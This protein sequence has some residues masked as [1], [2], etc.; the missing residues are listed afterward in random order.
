MRNRRNSSFAGE[1]GII[2]MVVFTG[3]GACSPDNDNSGTK[4][5]AVA[6]DVTLSD[7]QRKN[8]RLYTVPE[9][10]YR[11]SVDAVGAVDFDSDQATSVLAPFSGPVA[12][13]FVTPGERVKKGQ[14]LATVASPDFA[15]AV[16]AYRKAV[17]AAQSARRLAD[18]DKDLL[19]HKGVSEREADQAESDAVGAEA[20]RA[21]ALQALVSLD[22]DPRTIA[23]I[24]RG[25]QS[26]H[27]EGVIRAPISGTVVEKLITPGQLLQ[28]GTTACFTVADLSRVW[29][30]AQVFGA[31]L[32]SI[33]VGDPATVSTG[34]ASLFGRVDN[35]AAEVDPNTRS[36]AVRVA[37][38]NPA[39][40]LKKQ[41]YVRARIESRAATRALMIPVS[42]VLRDDENLPFVY[43]MEQD[44]RFA[45]RHVTL[46]D[47]T[48]A[49][50]AIPSGLR[51]GERIVADGALF[52]QFMQEQ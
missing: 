25:Q 3:L 50:Y 34:F 7:A 23:D 26:S 48:G 47:R 20:D 10:A 22:I 32:G 2:L 49:L 46:G 33:H 21:A 36:V 6:S 1:I 12:R 5:S 40:T 24:R 51:A 45:R 42:G 38:D 35:I 8:I 13:I 15:A 52:L 31:D 28:A 37:V 41:M 17:A 30:M 11:K 19:A 43:V 4:A 27:I 44:G 18:M 14:P 16:S 9:A 29:V 39:G